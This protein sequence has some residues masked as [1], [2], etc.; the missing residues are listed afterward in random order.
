[1][2]LVLP[3]QK[4]ATGFASVEAPVDYDPEARWDVEKVCHWLC[5]RKSVPLGFASVEAPVDYDPEARWDVE[6]VCHWL[7]QC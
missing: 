6:K 1:M 4:C 7:C 5:Q 3:A 2:P